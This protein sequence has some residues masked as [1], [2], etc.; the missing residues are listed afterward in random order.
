MAGV[1]HGGLNKVGVIDFLGGSDGFVVEDGCST[2]SIQVFER[3]CVF[4]SFL[5]FTSGSFD[6]TQNR[7]EPWVWRARPELA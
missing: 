1:Y 6:D 3:V 4:P 2:Q 7:G 5:E